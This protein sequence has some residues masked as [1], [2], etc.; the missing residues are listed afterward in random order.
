MPRASRGSPTPLAVLGLAAIALAVPV[1]CGSHDS[2]SAKPRTKPAPPPAKVAVDCRRYASP[3]GSDRSRG[4]R[5]VPYRTVRR[6]VRSLRAGQTGC[7]LSGTY[8]HRRVV[9]LRRPRVT[10]R[11]A[12]GARATI[13][14]ALEIER[15][16]RHVTVAA[17]RLTSHNRRF[18]TPLK[19]QA[20]D[21][22]VVRNVIFGSVDSICVQVGGSE[23]APQRV[24]IEENRIGR[25]SREGKLD[26]QIYLAETRDSVVRGN[27]LTG[28]A[29]GWGVHLYP[30][31]DATLVEH[32]VID[33]DYGGVVFA[34][35]GHETS[36]RNV[37]R[38]NAITFSTQRGNLEGS[39]S[40]GPEGSGNVAY[41]NCLYSRGPG[42]PA[43]LSRTA[44]FA[45]RGNTVLRGSPYRSRRRRDYRFRRNSP[46]RALVGDVSARAGRR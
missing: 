21:A 16:A 39:W 29:G 40:G 33:G 18:F 4:T 35:D 9:E 22:R 6:L 32:N 30:N 41:N 11:S 24:V 12:P 37:V 34:G 36:D 45:A 17:L 28:N 23:A 14:G 44:G 10:L 5:R 42:A 3:R 19:V 31:A 7:L 26:H 20:S 8:R 46:C 13:D 2:P 25:C 1:G 43:G 15:K 38:N 27:V